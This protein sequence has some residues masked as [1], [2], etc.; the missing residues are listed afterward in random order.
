MQELYSKADIKPISNGGC[1]AESSTDTQ[2]G[3]STNYDPTDEDT[4]VGSDQLTKVD[5]RWL[6]L[7]Q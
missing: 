6:Q 1:Q 3:Q 5:E 7:M 2:D 4:R